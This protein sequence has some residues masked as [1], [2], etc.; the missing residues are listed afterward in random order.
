MPG[1]TDAGVLFVVAV[2]RFYLRRRVANVV[3]G[4]CAAAALEDM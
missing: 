4:S 3:D 1:L 2:S